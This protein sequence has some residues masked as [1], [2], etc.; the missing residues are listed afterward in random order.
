M[1]AIKSYRKKSIKDAEAILSDGK[2]TLSSIEGAFTSLFPHEELSKAQKAFEDD[3]TANG[4][5]SANSLLTAAIPAVRDMLSSGIMNI[6]TLERYIFLH[7]PQMEDGNNFGV[8]VQ[9][10]ISKFLKET[11]DEWSKLLEEFPKYYSTRADAVDKLGLSKTSS[12]ETKTE[13]KSK[14][15]GGEKGDEEKTSNSVVN[16]TKTSNG[17]K[18]DVH[19]LNHVVAIDVKFYGD[20][21][22]ALMTLFNG[23]ITILDNME[24]NQEKLLSPKG[25]GG[26]AMGMY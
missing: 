1:S 9:M 5:D 4:L 22:A 18:T 20:L 6:H 3:L 21:R 23:Y 7:V 8:T 14:S 16:E 2:K 25:G 13:S 15:T 11:R 19:R 17:Q 24:K 10:T 12:S 26:G